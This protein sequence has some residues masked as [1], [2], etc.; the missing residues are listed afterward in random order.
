MQ[1][2]V[3][4]PR[5][6]WSTF[7][8]R[9]NRWIAGVLLAVGIGLAG[10]LPLAAQGAQTVEVSPAEVSPAEVSPVPP[11]QLQAAKTNASRLPDGIYLYGQSEKVEQIGKG[12]FVFEVTK[13]NVVGALYM[14]RSSFDCASG[15]FKADELAL[16]VVNSY[17][18]S[19][20][21]FAISLEKNATVASSQGPLMQQ[22]GLQG[23]H[24]LPKPS[25]NDLRMLS[26][27]KKDL[28]N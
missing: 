7:R 6:C 9:S 8:D 22:L 16:T 20:N 21:P 28:A 27:C 25:E 3:M 10:S 18:R 4:M 2:L 13:G 11:A 15:S 5:P 26:V 14:P 12:Y 23:F 17:D 24:Q 1:S 19:T